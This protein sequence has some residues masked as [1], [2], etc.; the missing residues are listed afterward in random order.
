ME[1]KTY[2]GDDIDVLVDY[3]Y[4]PFEPQERGY[5][6]CYAEATINAVEHKG[7]D[8]ADVLSADV[9]ANL[10]MECLMAEAPEPEEV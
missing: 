4:Q 3:D 9:M 7:V 10:E 2:I 1:L 6:G 5:P 8:I